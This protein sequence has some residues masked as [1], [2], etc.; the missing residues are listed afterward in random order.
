MRQ[1]KIVRKIGFLSPAETTSVSTPAAAPA[2][3]AA[4]DLFRFD[5]GRTLDFLEGT[6]N[7]LIAGATGRGK[8]KSVVEPCLDQLIAAGHGGIVIDVKGNCTDAART[9]AAAHGRAA[10]VLELGTSRTAT[11]INLFN[12]LSLPDLQKMVRSLSVG[13]FENATGNLDWALKGVKVAHDL[14]QLLA[15]ISK[16][17][18]SFAPNVVLV[19][20]LLHNFRLSRGVMHYF[21]KKHFDSSNYEHTL[22][23]D[24]LQEITFH[25]LVQKP[26]S[27]R[28][29][30]DWESQTTWN[31]QAVRRAFSLLAGDPKIRRNFASTLNPKI[32]LDFGQ[33]VYK[34]K[35][36][37]ILRFDPQTTAGGLKIAK[38]VKEK[39]YQDAYAHGLL[40]AHG[41]FT[42]CVM[43][44]FQDIIDLDPSN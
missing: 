31:L 15:F 37:V 5:S 30:S 34:Q 35:K 3:L 4:D 36:I 13:E 21:K 29:L 9:M 33:L 17:E 25:P 24:E 23:V 8:S 41:D 43:D 39:F 42:F 6:F 26:T 28:A 40:L 44:E 7:V 11:P 16:K 2:H 10:D 19:N 38:F 27:G 1:V 18:P 20:A 12:G 22:F 14:I 32:K